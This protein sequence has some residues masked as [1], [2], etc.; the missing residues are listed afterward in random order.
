MTGADRS[1][2]FQVVFEASHDAIFVIDPEGDRI[3]DANPRAAELLGYPLEELRALPVSA[4]HPDEMERLRAF[5]ASVVRAGQGWTDELSCTARDG[6]RVPSEISA[7]VVEHD[8]ATLVVAIVRDVSERRRMEAALRESHAALAEANRSLEDRVAER[9]AALEEAQRELV[10]KERLAAIGTFASGIVHEIRNPLGTIRMG[11]E[12][13]LKNSPGERVERRLGLAEREVERLALLLDDILAYGRPPTLSPAPAE[14]SALVAESAEVVRH[15]GVPAGPVR[16]RACAPVTVEADADKLRQVLVNLLKNAL[17]A[18]P[19]GEGVDV[20]VE[21]RAEGGAVLRVHNAG[22]PIPPETLARLTRP[23]VSTKPRG[24]GLGLAIVRRLVE[25][26]GGRLHIDS[27]P[28]A[29]TT[30]EVSLNARVPQES[31]PAA[32]S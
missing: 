18:A 32:A 10:A 3:V 2:L 17:E 31:P 16:C 27:A 14:L 22:E 28:G 4:V 5:A 7:S 1:E 13:A 8:G 19:P 11:V 6:C 15:A 30:I 20:T 21:A 25:A 12:Y 24:T 23:F 26:H 9:N 29:G